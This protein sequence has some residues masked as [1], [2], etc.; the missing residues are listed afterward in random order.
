MQNI[1]IGDGRMK[2]SVR[3]VP[4]LELTFAA[5]DE[6][7]AWRELVASH[8][9]AL[10]T[11]MLAE[12]A[13]GE[14]IIEVRKE[15]ET[16]LRLRGRLGEH[17]LMKDIEYLPEQSAFHVV[18]TLKLCREE[19]LEAFQDLWR[20]HA[21]PLDFCWVPNLRPEDDMVIGD[22][23]FRSPALIMQQGRDFAALVPDLDLLREWR[24]LK[25]CL[26]FDL[27]GM[28]APLFGY[29]FKEYE[30]T[31]HTYYRHDS[32]MRVTLPP[33]ELTFGY[34]LFVNA[35]ADKDF[36]QIVRFL[37]ER[38]AR[39][40]LEHVEPQTLPFVK[41]AEYAYP[42]VVRVGEYV[43]FELDGREVAGI[44]ALD[45]GDYFGTPKCIVWNQAWFNNLRSAYGWYHY[46]KKA[47]RADWMERAARIKEWSLSAPQ[48]EGIFP[49][50][51]DLEAG[52]WWGSVPRLNGD[53][54]R[55]HTASASWT[56]YW[57]LE[58]YE[59]L[60]LD[61]RLLAY[62]RAYGD[63]LVEAQLPSGAIPGWFEME[64]L[65][66]VETLKESA[67]TACSSLFLA[68]LYAVTGDRRYLTAL[69]RACDF[70]IREVVPGHKYFD[71]ETFFSCS[72][73]EVGFFDEHTGLHAHNNYSIYWTAHSLLKAYEFTGDETY[74]TEGLAALDV[75]SLYQ[76]VWN[77]PYLSLYT[78]G[79]FG[80]MNTDGEWNDSRQ[81]VFPYI[82]MEAYRLSGLPEYSERGVAALRASF[83][84]M[85]I[86]E[87]KALSPYTWDRYPT[88]LSPENFAHSGVDKTSG[89]S[90][91]GWGEGGALA[92]SAL[93]EDHF[94]GLYV[95]PARC[96][97][98]GIDGCRVLSCQ[99]DG[100]V[101]ELE[102]KEEL[103]HSREVE[104]MIEEGRKQTIRLEAGETQRFSLEIK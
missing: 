10:S 90:D 9:P 19:L 88:G 32:S 104:V 30:S 75:L 53:R 8:S 78:F 4:S 43:E 85:A 5:L 72:W 70:L 94:G 69:R 102:V 28:A 17:E 46:G 47:G 33:Q 16:R 20:F 92:G 21:Q 24:P 59:H 12:A 52:E 31:G 27:K 1:G 76:Q 57:M 62:A 38:Y 97:A 99:V 61:E 26:E 37:W 60:E 29:G 42:Q 83:V 71:Y 73:K 79:G 25:A 35:Q 98:F 91:F 96:H 82:Y 7:G 95:D 36:R 101:V 58:W 14:D 41:Y 89:R 67:E 18:S 13:R 39:S 55:Y 51:Y 87:N 34:Y 40:Y 23:V 74:L 49:A 2:L 86:P 80:V 50:I 81:A 45:H 22:H 44:K 84:L 77:P 93:V 3:T 64:G 68:E 65:R 63:F 56:A 66:P 100:K 6:G 11:V 48:Q 103:G 54:R 15:S